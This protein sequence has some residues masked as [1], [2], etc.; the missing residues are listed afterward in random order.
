MI[1]LLKPDGAFI[2]EAPNLLDMFERLAFDS[3]Y[4]EHLSYLSI[5]PLR[6]LMQD[7]E[8]EIFDVRMFPV[9]G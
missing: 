4:H 3:I 6:R 7:H 5:R 2:F 9:Q 8:M 1:T